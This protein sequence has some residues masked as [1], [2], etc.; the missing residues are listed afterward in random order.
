MIE[1]ESSS[2]AVHNPLDFK[3]LGLSPSLAP[4]LP[5]DFVQITPASRTLYSYFLKI[6]IVILILL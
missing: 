6:S 2:G 4:Y 3:D 1:L 5:C